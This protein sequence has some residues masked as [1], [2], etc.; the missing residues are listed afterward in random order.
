MDL[1]AYETA[2]F[3]EYFDVLDHDSLRSYTPKKAR[4]FF[5]WH[6]G[7]L[8]ERIH[9]LLDFCAKATGV[10]CEGLYTFPDGILP[11]WRW[12]L[13]VAK[14]TSL[15]SE[16]KKRM[17]EKLAP[18][19]AGHPP[20][21]ILDVISGL[22]PDKVMTRE[23][24]ALLWDISMY[25]GDGFTR[26][27]PKLQWELYRDHRSEVS[28]NHPV[29]RGFTPSGTVPGTRLWIQPISLVR[30]VALDHVDGVGTEHDL[31]DAVLKWIQEI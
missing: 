5:L 14:V 18:Q 15:S 12:F 6:Q 4:D 3:P 29:V 10:S 20:Q 7:V 30:F 24:E 23:T 27:S 19:M 2:K 17:Y 26:L 9:Y 11:L 1:L 16:E 21:V 13:Q 31:W 22:I 28:Y 25:V 8:Q